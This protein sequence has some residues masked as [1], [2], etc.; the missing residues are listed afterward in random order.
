MSRG[1]KGNGKAS[2]GGWQ[3]SPETLKQWGGTAPTGSSETGVVPEVKMSRRD[4][5]FAIRL[6]LAIEAIQ[7]SGLF[8]DAGRFDKEKI[9]AI[10]K[11]ELSLNLV[12]GKPIP[13]GIDWEVKAALER[14][15]LQIRL[16]FILNADHPAARETDHMVP[17][18]RS[19]I[20]FLKS[21]KQGPEADV[22]SINK[23]FDVRALQEHGMKI[24]LA[25]MEGKITIHDILKD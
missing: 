21:I 3:P 8:K 10:L 2:S 16:G 22:L 14:P 11:R 15:N 18:G 23:L 1:G 9:K 6:L 17:N 19:L 24:L 20:A 13:G 5:V 12:E 25:V 7:E 4:L